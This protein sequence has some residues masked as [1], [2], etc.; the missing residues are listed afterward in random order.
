M[1]DQWSKAEKV[2]II[3]VGASGGA[4]LAAFCGIVTLQLTRTPGDMA[5]G[6]SWWSLFADPFAFTVAVPLTIIG[7]VLAFAYGLLALWRTDLRRSV[8][9]VVAIGVVTV[10]VTAPVL[11]LLSAFAGLAAVFIALTG[12]HFVSGAEGERSRP[13]EPPSR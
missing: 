11:S 5:H 12:Y 4:V 8:P 2:F 9:V 7:A 3:G 13:P 10:A 6:G 1:E